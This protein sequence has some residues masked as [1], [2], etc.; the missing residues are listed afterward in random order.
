MRH[1]LTRWAALGLGVVLALTG[2]ARSP[3]KA[4]QAAGP[5]PPPAAP[6]GTPAFTAIAMIDASTGWAT[7]GQSSPSGSSLQTLLR[8]T[9]GGVTWKD[10][11]PCFDRGAI[12]GPAYFFDASTAWL[13][14]RRKDVKAV[15]VFRTFDGGAEWRAT[16]V[17]TWEFPCIEGFSV[18][19]GDHVWMLA[20]YGAAMGS[21]PTDIFASSDG[22]DSWRRV[23]S[24]RPDANPPP[25]ALP[26]AG[27]KMGLA[28]A[29][30]RNGWVVGTSHE[31]GLWLQAT[32]DGGKT[33]APE[34]LSLPDDYSLTYGSLDTL[35]P[36][37]FRSADGARR[38]GVLGVLVRAEGKPPLFYVTHDAG[39]SWSLAA[40]PK[41]PVTAWSFADAGHGF[42]L[43][44]DKLWATADGCRTW[45]EIRPN[46]TLTGVTQLDFV[47]DQI[48]WAIGPGIYLKTV[49]GGKAWSS[50]APAS[51]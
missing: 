25:G 32:S 42:A 38:D 8:T 30:D 43:G 41:G 13:A 17:P 6:A 7:V 44:G 24:A 33:W 5:A 3:E 10:V 1:F 34:N 45:T 28:F 46:Y 49:D 27:N 15:A 23:A 20:T 50:V 9:D 29:D 12:V 39:E 26:F 19:D 18:T 2:C 47:S 35:P 37:F 11:T 48:G 4:G 36:I 51:E 40:S 22:G 16:T 14:V 31:P 21:E